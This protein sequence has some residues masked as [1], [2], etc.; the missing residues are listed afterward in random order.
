MH[1]LSC[2]EGNYYLDRAARDAYRSYLLAYASHAHRD[3]FNFQELYLQAVGTAFGFT[4]PLRVDTSFGN[5]TLSPLRSRTVDE[6]RETAVD[7][8]T[9]ERIY[10][11][12]NQLVVIS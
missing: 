6:T 1:S 7:L 11:F 5:A 4:S 9:N 12:I 8:R 10:R 3:T 2:S